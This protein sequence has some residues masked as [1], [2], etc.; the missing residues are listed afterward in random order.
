M[1][2]IWMQ[3]HLYPATESDACFCLQPVWELVCM[4]RRKFLD[5]NCTQLVMLALHA[6]AKL[7]EA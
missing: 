2:N 3:I 6:K 7:V 4:V 5:A 1:M